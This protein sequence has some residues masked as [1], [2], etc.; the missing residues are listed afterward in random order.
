MNF[1]QT[2][3]K[4]NLLFDGAFGTYYSQTGGSEKI[5]EMA[6]FKDGQTV[7][8][9]HREY[10]EAGAD[11]IRTNTFASNCDTLS[12]SRE[13]LKQNLE[14]ACSLAR[15]AIEET[16]ENSG[17]TVWIA[18]D[19][20]PLPGYVHK[21]EENL[22]QYL[23]IAGTLIRSGADFL[24]FETFSD[25]QQILPVAEQLRKSYPDIPVFFHFSTNQYGYTNAG[26]SVKRI[27]EELKNKNCIDGIGLNCGV[28]PGHML[29]LI[30]ELC[31]YPDKV[32]SV[33]PNAS[34]PKIMQGRVVFTGDSEYFS[35]KLTEALQ[36]G[37]DCVGGCCGTT[38]EYI[39]VVRK[40]FIR[41]K[42]KNT[43]PCEVSEISKSGGMPLGAF[44]RG[45]NRSIA[46][47]LTPP[48]GINDEK[49][50]D[51]AYQLKSLNVDVITFPDS[52]SGRTR[53]DSV[54]MAIKAKDKSGLC[55]MPHLCCRDK[56]AIAVRSQLLGAYMNGIRNLLI[57]T[58]DPVP[59]I[60]RDDIKSVYNFD[61]VGFMRILQ[62]M[63]AEEFREDPFAY[64][65]ALNPT[66]ANLEAEIQR[67]KKKMDAGASFF[68]TQ[69][70]F[71]DE[72]VENLSIIRKRVPDA[73]IL[74]GI[75]PLI[76]Y[77]NAK[78]MQSEMPGIHVTDAIVSRYKENGTKEEGE[79][80]GVEL[81]REIIRK[82]EKISDGYY[83][84]VPFN[85][86]YLV[87]DILS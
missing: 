24:L 59:V 87:K 15:Q 5:P 75:M 47:E 77:K 34:Y 81:A 20:G 80:A 61:S 7:K 86:V 9:I 29:S 36:Y 17:R 51:A 10:I 46:V 33:L 50:L 78:F 69:P 12:C 39:R 6:N 1:L 11:I 18:G 71:T 62:E 27:F 14:N 82:T 70:L 45:K 58:G 28:G 21:D 31:L 25:D 63:N 2:I 85:R 57:V 3:K 19:I 35:G 56:N 76:S 49:V 67:L 26:I 16:A 43:C 40:H 38:P 30:Q 72:D 73:R 32:Y 65:G 37:V 4:R 74:C 54:L 66:C 8:R 55:V 64:G 22:E 13:M 48:F 42:C 53:A 68:L 23:Y 41:E 60:L 84:S 52:P 44:Y 83:F 79:Q